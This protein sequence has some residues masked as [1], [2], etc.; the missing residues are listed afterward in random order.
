M[1]F[2]KNYINGKFVESKATEFF[3]AKNPALDTTIAK[4]PKS[5]KGEVDD[6]VAVAKEAFRNWANVPGIQR[7]QP[8]M[9]LETLLRE[10]I[11]ALT[12]LTVKNHGKE[13]SAAEGEV[14]RAYQM[15]DAA[16]A[17]PEMQ[18]GEFM[19]EIVSGIDE[20]SVRVPLGVFA[21]IPPF[22]F[23]V[24]IPFW[25]FPFAI[26][27]GNTY[28]IKSNEQTPL[29]MQEV[30]ELIDKCGFPPGVL[31]LIHGGAE[32]ANMLIDHP[33][34][35]GVSSVGSTPTAKAIYRRATNLCK[36]A[37][38]HGGA[39]NFLVVMSDANI[40]NIMPNIM[41][42]VYGNSGQRC[43]AGK[44]VIAV[45]NEKFYS[46]FKEKY[47]IAAKNLKVGSGMEKDS[48]MGPLVSKKALDKVVNDIKRGVEEGAKLILDGRKIKI[49]GYEKGYFLGPCIFEGTNPGMYIYKE[50]VF[51]PV[52]HLMHLHTLDE[53]IKL[54]N[55]DP[56]GNAT[57]IYTESGES[58]RSF[59]KN[60][61][62]GNIGI[63]L[64]IV[65]PLSYFPFAG[66]KESFFGT[67][68]AQGRE[69]LEFF[70]QSHVVIERFHGSTKIEW[71]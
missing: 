36:R 23:P 22:N 12:E 24:M 60:V 13:W 7:I 65:A 19:E 57:T 45:G 4:V 32:V 29:P 26:A 10:N 18:K 49:A 20:Y 63:N 71:D 5:L 3:E 33:D 41:N 70:T 27:A 14:V 44:K 40:D 9:K 58:A 15:I 34:V 17:I 54:I 2:L 52:A 69:A 62:A 67:L 28:I 43:L 48:F 1:E 42:S 30:F 68:R 51:G 39:N 64:G 6:T 46:Y 21:M 11:A 16:L 59:R 55:N 8:L 25:F 31:N 56:R 66:T 38:C 50:E 35:M 61:H 53:A 37:Q 47:L